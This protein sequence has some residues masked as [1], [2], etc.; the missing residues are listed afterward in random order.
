MSSKKASPLSATYASQVKLLGMDYDG[1]QNYII[2]MADSLIKI[3]LLNRCVNQLWHFG[4][5]C[6]FN[7]VIQQFLNIINLFTITIN[8]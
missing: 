4:C 1:F 3:G 7:I 6:H 2:I 5:V 8:R